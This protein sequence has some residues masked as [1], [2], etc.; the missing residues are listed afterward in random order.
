MK[1]TGKRYCHSQRNEIYGE[2][3][4]NK[5][6][7]FSSEKLSFYDRNDNEVAYISD[8][9]LYIMDVEVTGSLSIGGFID[10]ALAD[11]GVVTKW[12]GIR[13]KG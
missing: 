10:T 13:G 6:A 8:K 9:K 12:V 11:G 3:V 1:L 2:E 7:R 4:F 5:Y